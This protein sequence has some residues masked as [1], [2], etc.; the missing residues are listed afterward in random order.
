MQVPKI[1]PPVLSVAKLTL[2]A[3]LWN[4]T[5]SWN[6]RHH[7]WNAVFTEISSSPQ[8]DNQLSD[9]PS[10]GCDLC[11][12]VFLDQDNLKAHLTAEHDGGLYPLRYRCE[13]ISQNFNELAT[14]N[15]SEEFWYRNVHTAVNRR[16]APDHETRIWTPDKVWSCNECDASLQSRENLKEHIRVRHD[17][18]EPSAC[19]FCEKNFTCSASL[20]EHLEAYHSHNNYDAGANDQ[21]TPTP[22]HA[23]V[24]PQVDGND[25]IESI[26]VDV[27]P[28]DLPARMTPSFTPSMSYNYTL[29][30]ENQAR[31]LT[32][33]ASKPSLNIVGKDIKSIHGKQQPA[34][35]TVEFNAGV[36]MSAIKTVLETLI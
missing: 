19:K 32:E 3:E 1:S 27:V 18:P 33:N 9:S 17:Q 10:Y 13:R 16:D 2:V 29:N 15:H 22:A 24:I 35:I 5:I 14:S 8:A 11:G 30:R 36:Y 31:R 21:F 20:R 6:T 4:I 26:D 23:D 7:L 28:I 34:S 12:N 25:S